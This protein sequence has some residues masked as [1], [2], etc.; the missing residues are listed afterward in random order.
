MRV[1]KLFKII[2]RKNLY[3]VQVREGYVVLLREEQTAAPL[4]ELGT[5]QLLSRHPNRCQKK[6]NDASNCCPACLAFSLMAHGAHLSNVLGAI[7]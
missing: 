1:L 3:H 4:G 5:A 7:C 2:F 6:G